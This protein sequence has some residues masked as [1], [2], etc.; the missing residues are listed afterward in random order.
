MDA[1]AAPPIARALRT[2]DIR[3]GESSI[4]WGWG[5]DGAA[6]LRQLTAASVACHRRHRPDVG[7]VVLGP[8]GHAGPADSRIRA[9]KHGP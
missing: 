1:S 7:P 6:T 8:V 9:A 3:G 4:L 2:S 5:D